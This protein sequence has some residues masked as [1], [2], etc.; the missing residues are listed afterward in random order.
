M[1][2]PPQ[3]TQEVTSKGKERIWA[4]HEHTFLNDKW[5]TPRD[6]YRRGHIIRCYFC[7]SNSKTQRNLQR[8]EILTWGKQ[9]KFNERNKTW[10]GSSL[11][12]ARRQ[13]TILPSLSRLELE[14]PTLWALRF[15][16]LRVSNPCP[17]VSSIGPQI[18][19]SLS[20][21][22]PDPFYYYGSNPTHFIISFHPLAYL[23]FHHTAP[24]TSHSGIS[25]HISSRLL[26]L[27]GK[28]RTRTDWNSSKFH[29]QLGPRCCSL[30]F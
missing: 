5:N 1:D 20:Y 2:L 25:L 3:R 14:Y 19:S 7:D 30:S 18:S 15:A 13:E 6:T 9:W 24:E 28:S 29:A 8:K 17:C 22:S 26:Y 27:V 4:I 12:A 23:V 16:N 11:L 21:L 10:S